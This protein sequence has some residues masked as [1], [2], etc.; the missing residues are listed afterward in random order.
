[1]KPLQGVRIV[2]VEQFGAAPYGTMLLADLGAEVIKIENAAIGGDPSRK[3]GPYML[4]TN[5]SEYFQAFNINKKSVSVD[6]RTAE[7]KAVLRE[8]ASGADALINNLRGDLPAKMGLDYKSMAA[9]NPA[10]VCVHVSAYG[11]DNARASWPGYDYLMQAESGLMHLT[12][13][14]DGPPSRLGAPSIIDHTTGL[15][16]A[17]GLLSAIIQAKTTGKGCDVDTCLLDVALHQLGYVATWYLNE[18]HVSTRQP[19]SAHYSVAPVQT[20]P[21]SDGWLFIMCMTDK[22]WGELIGAIGRP[23]LASDPRFATQ[24]LRQANRDVLTEIID[25][26]LRRQSN[27]Y[28]LGK[29]NGVLPVAPVLDLAQALDS[30]FLQTTDMIHVISHPAKPDMRVLANPIK[31]NGQRLEQAPCSAFGADNATYVGEVRAAKRAGS[32]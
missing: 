14:P 28:W 1:M 15:T 23:E 13:E 31:I 18:G 3:T 7:G 12:G 10:I 26:E 19:R 8:L 20:F 11:R 4:G 27:A 17:V 29:L 6:L 25:A 16:A 2:S 9:V 32:Q 22:F 24:A 5:D 21:T 30:P